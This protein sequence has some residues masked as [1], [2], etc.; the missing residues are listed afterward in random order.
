MVTVF[1]LFLNLG[2]VEDRGCIHSCICTSLNNVSVLSY[3]QRWE[4]LWVWGL[5][6][7]YRTGVSTR[8]GESTYRTGF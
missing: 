3:P 8:K 7:I 2:S 1:F 6:L 4:K 5:D